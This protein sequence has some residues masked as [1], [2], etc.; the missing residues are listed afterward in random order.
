M[1][2]IDLE[3]EVTATAGRTERAHVD[4]GVVAPRIEASEEILLPV[5]ST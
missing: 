1:E 4:E 3:F 2:M 5:S